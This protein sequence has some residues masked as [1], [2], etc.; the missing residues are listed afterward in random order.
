M[1]RQISVG[2]H[3]V[4]QLCRRLLAGVKEDAGAHTEVAIQDRSHDVVVADEVGRGAVRQH[5]SQ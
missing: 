2:Q 5:D 4:D 3:D 1:P